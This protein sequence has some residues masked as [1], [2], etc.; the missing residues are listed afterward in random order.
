MLQASIG[1]FIHK[2]QSS[3]LWKLSTLA[4]K[5]AASS[6]PELEGERSEFHNNDETLSTTVKSSHFAHDVYFNYY[7]HWMGAHSGLVD[8]TTME[9]KWPVKKLDEG[10]EVIATNFEGA[11]VDNAA[12]DSHGLWLAA[13]VNAA[14]LHHIV[15]KTAA[16]Q[17][18]SEVFDQIQRLNPENNFS[19]GRLSGRLRTDLQY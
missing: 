15:P 8:P 9:A 17:L 3:E 6:R 13:A 2:A 11:G 7:Y 10:C 14:I 4:N 5:Y 16:F 1:V 18:L 12:C 19:N